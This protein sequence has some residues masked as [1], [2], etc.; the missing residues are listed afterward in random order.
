MRTLKIGA[1]PHNTDGSGYYRFYLPFQHLAEQSMHIYAATAPGPAPS[2]QQI[3]GFDV[4]ALQRPAGRAGTHLLEQYMG[5]GIKL[6]YETDDD[7]L[8][9]KPFGP[10]MLI[11]AVQQALQRDPTRERENV[12]LL[13]RN[14]QSRSR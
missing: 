11:E 5:H 3:E 8:L 14:E 6:V 12:V 4:L 2:L 13:R 9:K 7:M 1:V 10:D